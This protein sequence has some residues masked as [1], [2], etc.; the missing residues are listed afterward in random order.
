VKT[1]YAGPRSCIAPG[2]TM[3]LVAIASVSWTCAT[4]QSTP[5]P[6]PYC[7]AAGSA[8]TPG[9]CITWSAVTSGVIQRA[10]SRCY[11]L[12]GTIGQL[13]PAPGYVYQAAAGGGSNYGVFSGF[14]AAAH[15]TG[16][17][18]IFFGEFEG[19]GP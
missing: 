13:A 9:Y 18:E 5:T 12:N 8:Q 19:C 11:R 16:L 10:G 15:T 2:S 17:D 1:S 3:M 4:A 14:Y 6:P 7:T